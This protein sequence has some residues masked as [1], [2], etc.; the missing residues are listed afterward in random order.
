MDFFAKLVA[1]LF[2]G[3]FEDDEL[4]SSGEGDDSGNSAVGGVDDGVGG[5]V[6][7]GNG[8][9]LE[10]FVERAGSVVEHVA[11]RE[12]DNEARAVVYA[13]MDELFRDRNLFVQVDLDCVVMNDEGELVEVRESPGWRTYS[14][15]TLYELQLR[16]AGSFGGMR[17]FLRGQVRYCRIR[18]RAVRP[19]RRVGGVDD[20]RVL[21]DEYEDDAIYVPPNIKCF[22][23]I[24]RSHNPAMLADLPNSDFR[25]RTYISLSGF[26]RLLRSRKI[27]FIEVV[28]HAAESD[29]G[30]RWR[31]VTSEQCL[32]NFLCNKPYPPV[33]FAT[34]Q[35]LSA[36]RPINHVVL[37]KDFVAFKRSFPTTADLNRFVQ[38]RLHRVDLWD[39]QLGD[40]KDAS[41]KLLQPRAVAKMCKGEYSSPYIVV[42]DFETYSDC[43]VRIGKNNSGK[44]QRSY[45]VGW[46]LLHDVDKTA[47]A[48]G[49]DDDSVA[50]LYRER[51]D[52]NLMAEWLLGI[53]TNL[54]WRG[55][56]MRRKPDRDTGALSNVFDARVVCYAHNG[57]NF[58]T[59]IFL[60]EC[61]RESRGRIQ[62]APHACVI[63]TPSGIINAAVAVEYIDDAGNTHI[64]EVVFR[65]SRCHADGS[66]HRLC[67]EFD[68]P[69]S[70]RKLH[71]DEFDVTE[72]T[73]LNYKARRGDVIPYLKNDV[74]SLAWIVHELNDI[75]L[76]ACGHTISRFLTAS[77]QAWGELCSEYYDDG[78]HCV[79]VL[80]RPEID[81]LISAAIYGGRVFA[82]RPRYTVPDLKLGCKRENKKLFK[83]LMRQK[84]GLIPLDATSLYPSAMSLFEY[85][86]GK[87]SY[88]NRNELANLIQSDFHTFFT[89][90]DK[91]F[92]LRCDLRP[93]ERKMFLPVCYAKTKH[94]N[95]AY[96]RRPLH[97]IVLTS[98]DLLEALKL[99]Y[100][101]DAV[102]EMV[103]WSTRVKCFERFQAQKFQD[104]L[105]H[106][107]AGNHLLANRCKLA[108]NSI[109]GKTCERV[110]TT[111]LSWVGREKFK[112]QPELRAVHEFG[113]YMLCE[114]E[115]E[116]YYSKP[117]QL[118][119][120][121]LAY[122]KKI[123]N[124]PLADL[125]AFFNVD[126]G[127]YYGDTDS[128]Y[129]EASKLD[130]LDPAYIGSD[131]GQLKNDYG[132]GC[133]II[134]AVF[135]APKIKYCLVLNRNG[136]LSEKFTAKGFSEKRLSRIDYINMLN[137]LAY[138]EGVNPH[139]S[140][141]AAN[142]P[143]NKFR[144]DWSFGVATDVSIHRSFDFEKYYASA[145]RKRCFD[146]NTAVFYPID[147]FDDVN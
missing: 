101:L 114:Y 62:I 71:A 104:R 11:V 15:R 122:S 121:I 10:E 90:H 142:D 87:A 67:E 37:V 66:L 55:L 124:A 39:L 72:I 76:T 64:V 54:A 1:R 147:W 120:F 81:E 92:I 18:A 59:W 9:V 38:A 112:R 103:E 50:I 35:L 125:D 6:R 110:I 141:T 97:K 108:A 118:G 32:Y 61:F 57:A 53:A 3:S 133:I 21:I 51:D 96:C 109:Y 33:C 77:G 131:L 134:D 129:I 5:D 40:V 113:D 42:Y 86:A 56:T 41:D 146:S 111:T 36:A 136:Y 8:R 45:A 12:Y 130:H 140:N 84:Q 89:E 145:A 65:D 7:V 22:L 137:G 19:S 105:L 46:M 100:R 29:R 107:K 70:I 117:R 143:L 95:I 79:E 83:R 13:I 123:M 106:K 34:V 31:F 98:V 93:P 139:N 17:V 24:I 23:S 135:I 88:Y 94:G 102:Y 91:L 99:G 82:L 74:L 73:K 127:V 119:A 14:S 44:K 126:S 4:S 115:T 85:P 48:R 30:S 26:K 69:E 138:T 78:M 20:Y 47:I 75:Y 2:V 116:P 43:D 25:R 68:V 52:Q 58:D 144:K 16:I 132:D 63:R 60:N 49:H 128:L 27:P 28:G 80:A